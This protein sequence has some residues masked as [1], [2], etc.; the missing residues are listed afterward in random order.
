[1]NW[2]KLFILLHYCDIKVRNIGTENNA[3]YYW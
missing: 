1:M 3:S 2:C